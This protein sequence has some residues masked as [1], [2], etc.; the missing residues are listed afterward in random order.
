MVVG[1]GAEYRKFW[2][3]VPTIGSRDRRCGEMHFM[4]HVGKV[5]RRDA[6]GCDGGWVWVGL[7]AAGTPQKPRPADLIH[8]FQNGNQALLSEHRKK[9]AE[10]YEEVTRW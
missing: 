4:V 5:R 2:T 7:L 3:R 10:K 9:V 1:G 8:G 6:G